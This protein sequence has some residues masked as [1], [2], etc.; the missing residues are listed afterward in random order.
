VLQART[1]AAA[2]M[3]AA[4]TTTASLLV[5]LSDTDPQHGGQSSAVHHD[6]LLDAL[7]CTCFKGCFCVLI[8]V[9]FLTATVRPCMSA[10]IC[11]SAETSCTGWLA[12]V[13]CVRAIVC[14]CALSRCA[15]CCGDVPGGPA[16][17][18]AAAA[19]VALHK[20]RGRP[21][22][23]PSAACS[24]RCSSGCRLASGLWRACATAAGGAP[25]AGCVPAVLAAAGLVA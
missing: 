25:G 6:G 15:Q 9:L 8:C 2:L 20:P 3:R 18:C 21:M 1:A 17:M 4:C 19:A 5:H 10:P 23:Q 7:I 16:G 13:M 14:L 22:A 24:S 12:H 11:H